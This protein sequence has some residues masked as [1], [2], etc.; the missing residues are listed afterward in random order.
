MRHA[1]ESPS[2]LHSEKKRQFA[3]RVAESIEERHAAKS[4]DGLVVV[5]P[6]VIMGDLRAAFSAPVKAAVA[7]ELAD[8]TNTPLSELPAHLSA[9][10]TL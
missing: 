5:A 1:L 2:D 7:T 3:R 4:F 8:L 9:H 10:V 6:A